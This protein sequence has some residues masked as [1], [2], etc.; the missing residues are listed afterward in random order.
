MTV[1]A[2]PNYATFISTFALETLSFNFNFY[3]NS[4]IFVTVTDLSGNITTLTQNVDYTVSGAGDISGGSVTLLKGQPIGYTITVNRELPLEQGT[5][6][7]NNA[8][9][10]AKTIETSLDKLLMIAQQLQTKINNLSGLQG[11]QGPPGPPGPP[12]SYTPNYK[13]IEEYPGDNITTFPLNDAINAI[14]STVTTLL[15]D[16]P[17]VAYVPQSLIYPIDHGWFGM[18]VNPINGNVYIGMYGGD[19]YMQTGGTGAFVAMGLTH[20]NWRS[21]VVNPLTG[22][23]YAAVS[24]DYIYMMPSGSTT[25]TVVSGQTATHNWYQMTATATGDIYACEAG[26]NW[27]GG[28]I[29]KQ[30]GGTGSFVALSQ[31]SRFWFG[32]AAANG[33]VYASTANNSIYMQTGGTGNFVTLNQTIRSWLA[34][35][36]DSSGNVYAATY[37]GDIFKQT[38]GT[39]NFIS[40]GQNLVSGLTQTNVYSMGSDA[41]GNVYAS[42]YGG[43]ESNGGIFKLPSGGSNFIDMNPSTNLTI[44]STLTLWIIPP[45]MITVPEGNTLTIQGSIIAP[46][47]QVFTVDWGQVVFGKN[48]SKSSWLGE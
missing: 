41:S 26:P 31:T 11:T 44:P 20:R 28:D 18:C 48:G 12:G 9:F 45:G 13:Y 39:G 29:W 38:A 40:M 8:P 14:G 46:D 42:V 4:E 19:I 23:L 35:T 6:L 27:A 21:L 3:H 15:V 22:D 34:M 1:E 43:G 32:M 36:A 16:S 7:A 24:F 33:N 5:S 25:F 17:Q 47:T 30:T 2:I 10:F 37:G